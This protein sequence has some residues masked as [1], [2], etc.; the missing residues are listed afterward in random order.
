MEYCRRIPFSKNNYFFNNNQNIFTHLFNRTFSSKF[1]TSNFNLVGVIDCCSLSSNIF[2]TQIKKSTK[3][4]VF[5]KR[6]RKEKLQRRRN[7]L[8][9][10]NPEILNLFNKVHQQYSI[11]T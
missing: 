10:V 2:E 6:T 1:R 5:F 11:T 4:N 8:Q 7:R 9:K 3:T